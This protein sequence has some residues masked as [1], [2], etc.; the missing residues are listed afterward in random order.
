MEEMKILSSTC[1]I[2]DFCLNEE[3]GLGLNLEEAF[4]YRCEHGHTICER[5]VV[6]EINYKKFVKKEAIRCLELCHQVRKEDY[7]NSISMESIER[8]TENIEEMRKIIQNIDKYSDTEIKDIAKLKFYLRSILPSENCI[9]CQ[10]FNVPDRE[11][12]KY[13]LKKYGFFREQVI[14]EIKRKFKDYKEFSK[15]INTY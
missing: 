8:I 7:F 6:K 1:Y 4:M 12:V 3:G 15:Y 11:L 2:C 14:E 9:V 10:T 5:H 13:L